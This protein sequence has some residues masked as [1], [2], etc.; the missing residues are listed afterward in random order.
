M[1]PRLEPCLPNPVRGQA[2]RGHLGRFLVLG[3]LVAMATLASTSIAG[4]PE[5][6]ADM[7][8]ASCVSYRAAELKMAAV[9]AAITD[10]NRGDR[11]FLARFKKWQSTWVI[12]RQAQLDAVYPHGEPGA[13]GSVLPMCRCT[14]LEELTS[15]RTQELTQWTSGIAEGDV[16]A[17][18]RAIKP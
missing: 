7:N 16:C 11:A 12:L 17:G 14:I 6:Q 3:L 18:S 10:K 13:Y 15:N 2:R 4:H 5:T 9:I 1:K 8:D